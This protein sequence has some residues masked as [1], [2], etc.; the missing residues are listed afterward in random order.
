MTP[1][2][3]NFNDFPENQLRKFRA[4]WTV[5]RQIGLRISLQAYLVEPHCISKNIWGTAFPAFPI[6]YATGNRYHTQR[7]YYTIASKLDYLRTQCTRTAYSNADICSAPTRPTA[8]RVLSGKP[9]MQWRLNI[10][11]IDLHLSTMK[12]VHRRH[13]KFQL[14][15]GSQSRLGMRAFKRLNDKESFKRLRN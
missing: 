2:G 1:G 15:H 13:V 12:I 3:N 11:P 8:E 9:V 10:Q 14:K 4:V 7:D 5:L 6:D